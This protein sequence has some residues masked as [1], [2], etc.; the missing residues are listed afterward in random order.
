[1]SLL[2]V[3]H[4]SKKLWYNCRIIFPHVIHMWVTWGKSIGRYVCMHLW[5]AMLTHSHALPCGMLGWGRWPGCSVGLQWAYLCLFYVTAPPSGQMTAQ[6]CLKDSIWDGFSAPW[7]KSLQLLYE[8]EV[9][10]FK[11]SS[12]KSWWLQ[13]TLLW[14][15]LQ[16]LGTK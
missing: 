8:S 10:T 15:P 13:P 6:W 3:T 9:T 7:A 1:M 2:C 12:K 4:L 5:D 14:G 11:V 16:P